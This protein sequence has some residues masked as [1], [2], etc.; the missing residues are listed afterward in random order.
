MKMDKLNIGIINE[1][2][3]LRMDASEGLP[4][5]LFLLISSLTPIPNVD[6]LITNDENQLLLAWRDDEY[7]GTGWHFPGGCIRFGET[8]EE[9]I[10]KTALKELGTEVEVLGEPI[11]VRDVICKDR[12]GLEYPNERGHHITILYECRLPKGFYIDNGSKK[13]NQEGYLKWFDFIPKNLL[14]VHDVYEEILNKWK[15]EDE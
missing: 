7:F 11:T 15:R 2:R 1:L 3:N 13:E 6:L 5:E 8:M 10:Q 14:N 9:R 12:C 4:E